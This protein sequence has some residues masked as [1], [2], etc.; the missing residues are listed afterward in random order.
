[1]FTIERGFSEMDTYQIT[2]I[3]GKIISQGELAEK[4]TQINFSAAQSGVY[5]LKTSHGIF[6]LLKN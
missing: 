4:Q 3:T 6:R 5:F 1:M 2:D